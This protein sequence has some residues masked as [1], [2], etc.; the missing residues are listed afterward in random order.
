MKTHNMVRY[1]NRKVYSPE[2]S[3]YLNLN[4]IRTLV[5]MGQAVRVTD[6]DTGRDWTRDVLSSVVG[7]LDLTPGQLTSI[8]RLQANAL[9]QASQTQETM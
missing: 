6:Y 2:L 5:Q 7:T 9:Q 3:K 8:I 4:D 1:S